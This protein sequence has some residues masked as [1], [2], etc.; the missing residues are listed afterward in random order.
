VPV[1]AFGN[2]SNEFVRILILCTCYAYTY[3][4]ELHWI[5]RVVVSLLSDGSQTAFLKGIIF[6][7]FVLLI[8]EAYFYREYLI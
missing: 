4:A 2:F 6:H 7:I 8:L 5:I 3:Y 1:I